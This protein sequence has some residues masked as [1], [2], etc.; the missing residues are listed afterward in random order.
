MKTAESIDRRRVRVSQFLDKYKATLERNFNWRLGLGVIFAVGLVAAAA[1]P[2]ANLG[3]P[4][5]IGF[6]IPFIWLMRKTTQIKA[7]LRELNELRAFYDRQKLNV[8]GGPYRKDIPI[9]DE[10]TLAHDLDLLGPRSLL[11][12]LDETVTPKGFSRLKQ[13]ITPEAKSVD[14]LLARQNLIKHL[15]KNTVQLVK[16]LISSR[17]R[18]NEESDNGSFAK[19][20][21]KDPADQIPKGIYLLVYGIFALLV[22]SLIGL[23]LEMVSEETT[24]Y[25]W[26]VFFLVS[27]ISLKYSGRSFYYAQTLE[28]QIPFQL[29]YVGKAQKLAEQDA[30]GPLGLNLEKTQ[31]LAKF[32]QIKKLSSLLS[33]QSHPLLLI[34]ING[35]VPWN[36]FFAQRFENLVQNLASDYKEIE[37]D[38][39]LLEFYTS[40]VLLYTY[41]TKT[42]PEFSKDI[43]LLAEDIYH[44]LLDRPQAVRNS[45]SISP[46]ERLNLI[47]GSNMSGKSTFLRTLGINQVLAMMGAPVFAKRFVTFNGLV[48]SCVRVSDSVEYGYS[49]FY[50][51]VRRVKQIIEEASSDTPMLYLIDEIFKGTNNYER[52]EGS[53]GVLEA[54]AESSS[55]GFVS[56]HDLE[57]TKLESAKASRVKNWH[58]KEDV[59]EGVMVFDYTLREGPSPSTNALKIM[60]DAGLPVKI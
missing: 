45:V 54:L 8:L 7:L 11:A 55:L 25:V 27:M 42:F 4:L 21:K 50:S 22:G 3:L 38:L 57:L 39:I 5:L 23:S 12:L 46:R 9:G 10:N 35:L 40:L 17:A 26:I 34:I 24:S 43:E 33:V 44:P 19:L 59:E 28:S 56:T 49:Y 31:P 29:K 41:Q 60:A 30:L 51:E 16:W 13:E 37:R 47:T 18:R 15:S 1:F 58:F 53:K 20:L 52:L 2:E 48:N 14:D 6:L 32:E 36:L